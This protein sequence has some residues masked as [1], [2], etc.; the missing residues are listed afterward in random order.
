MNKIFKTKWNT[1]TQTYTVCSELTKHAGKTVGS[2]VIFSVISMT[3]MA[4]SINVNNTSTSGEQIGTDYTSR[5]DVQVENV[6]ITMKPAAGTTWAIPKGLIVRGGTN[7]DISGKT[8][9]DVTLASEGNPERSADS[10][11]AYGIAVG[12]EAYGGQL[13]IKQTLL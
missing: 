9:I 7:A 11:A 12:Y 5:G 3:A 2:A 4:E 8:T 10:N 13:Q 1:V 6:N